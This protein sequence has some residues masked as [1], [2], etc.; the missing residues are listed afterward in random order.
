METP[1]GGAPA[2]A[3]QADARRSCWPPGVAG[4]GGGGLV[5]SGTWLNVSREVSDPLTGPSLATLAVHGLIARRIATVSRLESAACRRAGVT[6]HTKRQRT[7]PDVTMGPASASALIGP[8]QLGA[9]CGDRERE[10]LRVATLNV[11][12]SRLPPLG[13]A[14]RRSTS[15]GTKSRQAGVPVATRRCGSPQSP[16]WM[17]SQVG[18]SGD[19][20]LV[21]ANSRRSARGSGAEPGHTRCGRAHD[22][23]RGA[24]P[25]DSRPGSDSR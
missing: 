25:A 18:S 6:G 4:G 8:E 13:R 24:R 15:A 22:R 11:T 16:V 19:G 2:D 7:K 1:R 20:V 14:L 17:C 12:R 10:Y 5:V 3:T 23:T 21:L 9:P